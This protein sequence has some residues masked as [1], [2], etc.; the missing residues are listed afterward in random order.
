MRRVAALVVAAMTTVVATAHEI[1]ENRLT[2]V[3]RDG[4]H[5]ALTFRVGLGEAMRRVVAPAEDPARFAARCAAMATKDF[6]ALLA[7]AEKKL[8]EESRVEA[9]SGRALVLTG[10]S[11]PD[12][13]RVQVALQART[14][15]ALAAPGGEA[16]HEEPLEIH[17]E[18]VA[19]GEVDAVAVSVP[20]ALQPVLVVSYRPRQA[21]VTPEAST[22]RVRF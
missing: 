15:Q 4:Q 22:V 5:L 11:F 17:A 13:R 21:W 20:A 9:A 16:P 19:A 6:D 12:P 1:A 2:L 8:V 10:W 18:A 3:Q 14:M 7:R